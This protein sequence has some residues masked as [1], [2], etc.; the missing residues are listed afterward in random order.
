[1]QHNENK[2]YEYFAK[3]VLEECFSDK[4]VPLVLKDKPDLQSENNL[5]G[6]EVTIVYPD[7]ETDVLFSKINHNEVRNKEKTLKKLADS[8]KHIIFPGVACS[9]WVTY[10]KT[11]AG[12]P[13]EFI[14]KAVEKK[15]AKLNNGGYGDFQNYGLFIYTEMLIGNHN[16]DD[17]MRCIHEKNQGVKKYSDIY[18]LSQAGIFLF[19]MKKQE[20]IK[21]E[22]S[23]QKSLMLKAHELFVTKCNYDVNTE[24]G[25]FLNYNTPDLDKY[26][27]D[28]QR[29]LRED[30]QEEK[31]MQELTKQLQKKLWGK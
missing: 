29:R 15:V 19:D 5:L 17:L 10:G 28:I 18:I 20:I 13:L 1:M 31:E 2:V 7:M 25:D 8:G 30:E 26:H 21:R 3:L 16:K 27:E 4:I 9:E 11:V 6:I 23:S 22:Y 14:V 12:S 24:N